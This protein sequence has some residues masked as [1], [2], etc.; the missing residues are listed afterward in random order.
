MT[1]VLTLK[2]PIEINGKKVTELKYDTEAITA[3][4]FAQADAKKML[5]SG[6][7]SG[8]LSGAAELDFSFHLYLG[9]AAIIAVDVSIDFSDLERLRGADIKEVMKIGRNFMLGSEENSTDDASSEPS[10]TTPEPTTPQ[11]QTSKNAR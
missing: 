1:G 11:S 9:F 3:Q 4:Q 6:T 5:A 8:N 10:E 7:K 2:N